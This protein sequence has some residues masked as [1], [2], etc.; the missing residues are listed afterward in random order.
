MQDL[1]SWRGSY[2][3]WR[4]WGPQTN[5][6]NQKHNDGKVMVKEKHFKVMEYPVPRRHCCKK[7][8]EGAEP[9]GC[10]TA[11]KKPKEVKQFS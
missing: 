2:L 11:A 7:S 8:V 4:Q 3:I 6:H 1:D 9:L 5:K 10:Q